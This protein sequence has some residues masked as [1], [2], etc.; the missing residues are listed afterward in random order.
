[1]PHFVCSVAHDLAPDGVLR[2]E[3]EVLLNGGALGL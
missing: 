2:K 1:M 3:A